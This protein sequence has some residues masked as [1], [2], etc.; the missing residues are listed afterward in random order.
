MSY[1]TRGAV[2]GEQHRGAALLAAAALAAA[3]VAIA[4]ARA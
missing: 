1:A 3:A 4:S 2:M